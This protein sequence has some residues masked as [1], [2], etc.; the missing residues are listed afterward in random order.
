MTI[1]AVTAEQ[2]GSGRYRV[3]VSLIEFL[4]K[5]A[6]GSNPEEQPDQEFIPA[7]ARALGEPQAENAA[8]LLQ[9]FIPTNRVA[10]YTSR[11]DLPSVVEEDRQIMRQCLNVASAFGYVADNETEDAELDILVSAEVY[12][13]LL[14]MT[15]NPPDHDEADQAEEWSQTS[16]QADVQIKHGPVERHAPPP[17]PLQPEPAEP[18]PPAPPRPRNFIGARVATPEPAPP[19]QQTEQ[20][21]PARRPPSPPRQQAPNLRPPTPPRQQAADPAGRCAAAA[22]ATLSVAATPAAAAT[23]ACIQSLFGACCRAT[24]QQCRGS[25]EANEA[26]D[27]RRTTATQDTSAQAR[28]G[29]GDQGQDYER[30]I[31]VRIG[32][33][34][35]AARGDELRRRRIQSPCRL[36]DPSRQ[37]NH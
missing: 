7:L 16:G 24:T 23:A 35:H 13:A 5:L 3:N 10:G 22:T 11:I 32:G 15:T 8:A 12:L 31:F 30:N 20:Q 4:I 29:R 17:Q 19:P 36:L 27:T 1:G 6:R 14:N 2:R 37:Q 25:A 26:Q 34:L 33:T 21:Q 28:R 18:P 9:Y